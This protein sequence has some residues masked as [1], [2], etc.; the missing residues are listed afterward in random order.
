MKVG[1]VRR[2]INQWHCGL[3]PS[4]KPYKDEIAHIHKMQ[5]FLILTLESTKY[6]D[7]EWVK[8]LFDGK[9]GYIVISDDIT[10]IVNDN[11]C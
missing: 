9:I 5:P 1:E 6:N 3:H 7:R 2:Y 10:E 8:V 4:P 11:L